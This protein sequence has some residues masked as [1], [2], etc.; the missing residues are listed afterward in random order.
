[1]LISAPLLYRSLYYRSLY[2]SLYRFILSFHHI[3]FPPFSFCPL[4]HMFMLPLFFF[5]P[6]G[7]YSTFLAKTL[8][9]NQ[10]LKIHKVL[11]GLS[12]TILS[13]LEIRTYGPSTS[14]LILLLP[15]DY[16]VCLA[17]FCCM[18]MCAGISL[19]ALDG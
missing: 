19:K 4:G 3:Y 16:S 11:F 1:M 18:F 7:P 15:C 2:F 13:N 14:G 6:L 10:N 17:L 9:N 5:C 12:V 8:I